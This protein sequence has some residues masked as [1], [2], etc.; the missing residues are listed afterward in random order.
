MNTTYL[1]STNYSALY[2]LVMKGKEIVGFSANHERP[3]KI[4]RTLHN[5]ISIGAPHFA[6]NNKDEF[7]S[8]CQRLKLEFILPQQISPIVPEGYTALVKIAEK[9]MQGKAEEVIMWMNKHLEKN[10][11]HFL[12]KPFKRL[13]DGTG[14]TVVLL[15][16]PPP[17]VPSYCKLNACRW[18]DCDCKNENV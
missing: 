10:P 13:L 16:L 18:P 14:S 9:G 6:A 17:H 2:D 15:E 7:I 1:T 3:L 12:C 5:A 8:E 11:D 4:K